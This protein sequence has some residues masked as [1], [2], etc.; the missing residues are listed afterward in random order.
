MIEVQN[1]S[2]SKTNFQEMS[3][4][5]EKYQRQYFWEFDSESYKKDKEII[6]FYY[7]IFY[8]KIEKNGLKSKKKKTI[9]FYN[10]FYRYT[11]KH[12]EKIVFIFSYTR[13]RINWYRIENISV[14]NIFTENACDRFHNFS[15]FYSVIQTM[16]NHEFWTLLNTIWFLCVHKK[17]NISFDFFRFFYTIREHFAWCS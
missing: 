1:R 15:D 12:K 16:K 17:N 14:V 11:T 9:H 8:K 2:S 6:P 5:H 4:K 10:V 13:A 3:S 7:S